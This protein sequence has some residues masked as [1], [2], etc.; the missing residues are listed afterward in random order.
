MDA[1]RVNTGQSEVR[2]KW[3]GIKNANDRKKKKR[4]GRHIISQLRF[5]LRYKRAHFELTFLPFSTIPYYSELLNVKVSS[6]IHI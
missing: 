3:G 1:E 6:C 2:K 4:L 5:E